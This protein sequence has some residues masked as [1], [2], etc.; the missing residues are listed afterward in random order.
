MLELSKTTSF[1]SAD[2]DFSVQPLPS[3]C[4]LLISDRWVS[5]QLSVCFRTVSQPSVENKT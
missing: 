4:L 1:G 5:D 3:L 2:K